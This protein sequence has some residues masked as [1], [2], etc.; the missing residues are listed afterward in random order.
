MQLSDYKFG[1]IKIDDITYTA[2]VIITPDRVID[3]WWRQQ[4]HNL[5]VDD[6]E[7]IIN[8]NPDV[9]IIGTGYYGR[10]QVPADTK[11]FLQQKGIEVRQEKTGD[12]VRL[13]GQLQ[14][15]YGRIVAA[16]HLTC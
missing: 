2:D 7:E 1:S 10:M 8:A 13:F 11:R 9:L 4:G 16:L 6:L 14:Q 12:A 5:Q 3:A 15:E